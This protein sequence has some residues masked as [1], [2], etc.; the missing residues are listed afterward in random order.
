[1]HND[2][3][4]LLLVV[5]LAFL[6]PIALQ[7]FKLRVIPVVVA[8][9]IVG[10]IIGNSGFNLIR[11]EGWVSQLST[12]GLIFLMFLS[13]LEL[14]VS[15]FKPKKT[16]KALLDHLPKDHYIDELSKSKPPN[17][18]LLSSLIFLLIVA[19]SYGC[20][21]FLQQL[22]YI[23]EPYLF[24]IM[25][26]SISLGVVV[27]V[28]K[29]KKLL[30]HAYGQTLLLITILSDGLTMILLGVYISLQSGNT[31]S[32]WL[33]GLFFVLVFVIYRFAARFMRSKFISKISGGGTSQIGTRAIFALILMLVVLSETLGVE[34]ILGAF[35]AGVI[36]SLLRP[37]HELVHQLES[38]GYGFLIPI[39]FIMIGVD[40][41][42]PSLITDWKIVLLI[43]LLIGLIFVARYVP[44][45]LL[46]F[47]FRFKYASSGG[48]LMASTLSLVIAAASVAYEL[49]IITLELQGAVVL[50]CVINCLLFP[51]LFNKQVP[52]AQAA[53]VRA[54]LIGANHV[55]LPVSQDLLK[56]DYDITVYSADASVRDGESREEDFGRFPLT[57]VS[58]LEEDTL[59]KAGAFHTDVIVLGSMDEVQNAKLARTAKSFG[60]E[61]IIVRAESPEL[62]QSLQSEAY[63]VFSTLFASRML[64]RGLVQYPSAVMLMS[65]DDSLQEIRV[66]NPKYN[67]AQLKELPFLGDA[68]ILR[69]YRGES[70]IIP[71][72]MTQLHS[73]DR[74][75]VSGS[76]ES[77]QA[78]K[79]ELE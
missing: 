7:Y 11:P 59:L 40:L 57:V 56:E 79:E 52:R 51:V 32:L 42:I 8:E 20:A 26:A 16:S 76:K 12:L 18:L 43:P 64:L 71:H 68:L 13:G 14:D 36:V 19:V 6:V 5:A 73:Q 4:S 46:G 75:L 67:N 53:R 15:L 49:G 41:D 54:S 69:I 50:V 62:I 25:I 17:P 35:L 74:L 10:L 28:L 23:T 60:I 9:I 70:I 22:N 63:S 47:W 33:L 30:E 78:L 1:M 21:V 38:F 66:Q 44:T 58:D 34:S 65:K 29:E 61:N 37:S 3:S 45:L 31:S 27:P 77:I 48:L 55:T 39:F 72:G 2:L 24:T